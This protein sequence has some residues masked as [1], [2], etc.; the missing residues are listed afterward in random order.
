MTPSKE[1]ISARLSRAQAELEEALVEIEK[2][3]AFEP[4]SVAFAAH[5]LNN[6]LAVTGATTEL[7]RF[8]LADLPNPDVHTLLTGLL[9]TSDLM[10]YTVA[11]LMNTTPRSDTVLVS[12]E[13]DLVWMT[14][15]A[16]E[17]YRRIADR[18]QIA[19][20]PESN[21]PSAVIW[22]DPVAVAATLDNLVT[23][24]IKF[25]PPG[26]QV[27]VRVTAEP[28]VVVCC[29]QD[30]GPGLSADDQ[31]RLFQRGAR[32]SAVPTA[33]EPSTGYG[34]AVAKE[35]VTRIGGTIWCDSRLGHGACFAFRLPAG[36]PPEEDPSAQLLPA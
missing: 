5:A 4:G 23:N 14:K 2:L 29:V 25:S 10:A 30:E 11:R 18:K 35:L 8:H 27:R 34:L 33:G 32:L 28:E 20:V 6:F 36:Q 9:H 1:Q 7:L 19:L 26:K 16:C 12:Q 3:P 22:T 21:T 17:Y 15:R 31:A 24:A 13:V